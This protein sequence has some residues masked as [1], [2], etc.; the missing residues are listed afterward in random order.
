[1]VSKN[2]SDKQSKNV[3]TVAFPSNA[4]LKSIGT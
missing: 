3:R 4:G 2:S 1:M